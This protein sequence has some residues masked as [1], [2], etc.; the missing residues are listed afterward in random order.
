MSYLVNV[1]TENKLCK[2]NGTSLLVQTSDNINIYIPKHVVRIEEK[3]IV[4]IECRKCILKFRFR[5]NQ[6]ANEFEKNTE[7]VI[8]MHKLNLLSSSLSKYITK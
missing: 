8:A 1:N 6:Q 7:L 4:H 2:Y 5:F 3:P